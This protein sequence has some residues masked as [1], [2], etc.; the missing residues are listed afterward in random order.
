M[1]EGE[2]KVEFW[3]RIT[4]R[5]LWA[6]VP[7]LAR[8]C[9]FWQFSYVLKSVSEYSQK[10]RQYLWTK[11]NVKLNFEG[12]DLCHCRAESTYQSILLLLYTSNAPTINQI[13]RTSSQYLE[14]KRFASSIH[15]CE[16][17]QCSLLWFFQVC[18]VQ[19]V[20]DKSYNNN[21]DNKTNTNNNINTNTT[22]HFIF[23][24][25]TNT[26]HC[27][28][29]ITIK[30]KI[31]IKTRKEKK[32]KRK[33]K[34]YLSLY[35]SSGCWLHSTTS[36]TVLCSFH[37]DTPL[38]LDTRLLHMHIHTHAHTI[39]SQ[40]LWIKWL[41]PKKTRTKQ[42]KK[43]PNKIK[44]KKKYNKKVKHN[45]Q[46]PSKNNNNS[47]NKEKEGM[48]K[49]LNSIKKPHQKFNNNNDNNNFEN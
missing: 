18:I 46:P 21:N 42:K 40:S 23:S 48:R 3:R 12:D 13:S 37:S 14:K 36:I 39:H 10:N 28:S 19:H 47:N 4:C 27:T 11:A 32:N 38:T 29:T 15:N 2:P 1:T 25:I 49:N 45:Q 41:C 17:K 31:T 16:W 30:T 44:L 43:K 33:N 7:A 26:L 35:L 22:T 5:K 9:N 20:D 24:T 34:N 6:R 8:K